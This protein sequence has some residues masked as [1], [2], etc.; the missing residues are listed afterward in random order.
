MVS[1]TGY[2]RI[3]AARPRRDGLAD[4]LPVGVFPYHLAV[5]E[6]KKVATS[7]SYLLA[8]RARARQEPLGNTSITTYP[9]AVFTVMNVRNSAEARGQ[10]LANLVL[11]NETGTLWLSS[12]R[13][14]ESRVVREEFHDP[15]KVVLIECI[16]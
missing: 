14:I 8:R 9:V 6:L 2:H 13:H 10:S 4:D 1:A 7:N 12:S 15:I 5:P 3:A 16:K 11:A